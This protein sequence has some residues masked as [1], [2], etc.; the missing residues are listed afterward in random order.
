MNPL[1]SVCAFTGK[2]QHTYVAR[3]VTIVMYMHAVFMLCRGH[4]KVAI[5]TN[6]CDVFMMIS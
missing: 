2:L 3:S 1:D 4:K 5:L 6:A